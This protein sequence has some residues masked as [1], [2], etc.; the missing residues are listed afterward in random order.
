MFLNEFETEIELAG[1]NYIALVSYEWDEQRP[2]I[3]KI[4]MSRTIKHDYNA[5][6]EYAPY[7][8]RIVL[9]ITGFLDDSQICAFMDQIQQ[10]AVER[11]AESRAEAELERQLYRQLDRWNYQQA[12]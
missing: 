8:E 6:G 1:A 10:D 7:V 5:M 11:A 3:D 9:D 4:E 12:A 2:L